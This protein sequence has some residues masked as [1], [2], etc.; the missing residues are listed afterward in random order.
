VRFQFSIDEMRPPPSGFELGH[1]EVQGRG[2]TVTSRGRSPDQAMM[3]FVAAGDLL[4]GVRAV[5]SG[6]PGERFEFIGT[7]SSFR[8]DFTQLRDGRVLLRHGSTEID[9]VTADELTSAVFGGVSEFAGRWLSTLASN[10]AARNDLEA[11]LKEFASWV[12]GRSG[13]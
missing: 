5:V 10:D 1:L 6:R 7:D 2:A 8:L 3:V 4:Y 9:T 11:S 12:S 13:R